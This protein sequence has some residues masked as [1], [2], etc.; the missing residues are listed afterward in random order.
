MSADH[1]RVLPTGYRLQTYLIEQVLGHGGFGITYLAHDEQLDRKVVIKEYM[2]ADLAT[3][4]PNSVVVPRSA[5]GKV[6]YDWGL[7]RFLNEARTLARFRRHPSIV[8]VLTLFE[9]KGTAYI[10]MPYEE[11]HSL[12]VHLTTCGGTLPA[13][14]LKALAKPLLD[15]LEAV[16]SENLL[17]RDIK[18]SNIFLRRDGS[19]MLLDF[20]TARQDVGSRTRTLVA[21]LTPGYAPIE[22]YAADGTMG[23]WS[24]IY[25]LG[26]VLYECL[27]GRKVPEAS[28]RIQAR[29]SGSPDPLEPALVVGQGRYPDAFLKSVDWSLK[30]L[31]MERPKSIGELR[32]VMFFDWSF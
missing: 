5:E 16:H 29:A 20:G 23:A 9:A 14:E 19:P 12:D 28:A 7:E 8:Q 15:G 27:S 32:E 6:N 18:P 22:Q 10:V 30:T 17:H 3:R 24:D 11:G 13:E 21:I 2:P 4:K 26:A 31:P 1:R 25:S